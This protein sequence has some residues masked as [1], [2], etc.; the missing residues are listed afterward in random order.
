MTS[1]PDHVIGAAPFLHG[2][3]GTTLLVFGG[4][5][6]VNINEAPVVFMMLTILFAAPGLYLLVAG[7]VARGIAVARSEARTMQAGVAE[8]ASP[9]E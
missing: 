9:S 2:L 8:G 7:A 1:Q 6:F 5:S 4:L 3:G